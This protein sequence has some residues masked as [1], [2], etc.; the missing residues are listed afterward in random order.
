MELHFSSSHLSWQRGFLSSSFSFPGPFSITIALARSWEIR[1][2]YRLLSA[3]RL[4]FPG[5]DMT[6]KRNLFW[7][8]GNY[9][10]DGNC[11]SPKWKMKSSIDTRRDYSKVEMN[12][13]R[14]NSSV[15]TKMNKSDKE[16]KIHNTHGPGRPTF[17]PTDVERPQSTF[18]I[19]RS[20]IAQAWRM[21]A[22]STQSNCIEFFFFARME[23]DR[24]KSFGGN[25]NWRRVIFS[26]PMKIC[27]LGVFFV[28]GHGVPHPHLEAVISRVSFSTPTIYK[29]G[30]VR[31]AEE[32]TK[33]KKKQFYLPCH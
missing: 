21:A 13:E 29:K 27:E 32:V 31:Q 6:K 33:W 23:V 19:D 14:P 8:V 5:H 17:C 1:R 26:V 9:Y 2:L 20:A 3:C 12:S 25:R 15:S 10:S 18:E 16:G 7:L 28:R 30:R 24:F 22:F 11:K 4:Q